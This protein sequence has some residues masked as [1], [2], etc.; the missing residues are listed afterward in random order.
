MNPVV[1]EMEV[2]MPEE[3]SASKNELPVK[4]FLHGVR[5]CVTMINLRKFSADS[6]N[7]IYL[8]CRLWV[9]NCPF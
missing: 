1:A 7:A 2:I 8:Y 4:L 6:H 9:K 5:L 3:I